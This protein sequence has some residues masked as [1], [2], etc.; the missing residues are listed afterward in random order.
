MAY[1][2]TVKM[3]VGDTGPD[4]KL[5]LKDS[6][7]APD[8][9]TYDANDSNTWAPIDLTGATVHLRIREVG[10]TAIISDLLGVVAA[11][12]EGSVAFSF[13]GNAFTAS[14][15]YEGE[16]EVTDNTGTVQTMYDLIKFKVREDF[17]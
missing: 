12:L 7:T 8:G 15:L 10:G 3:V 2:E 16:V 11:P 6:N 14:G 4:I 5:T 17:D 9:V 1:I 13:V